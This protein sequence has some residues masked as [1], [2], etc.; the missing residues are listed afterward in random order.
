MGKIMGKYCKA[1]Q[2]KDLR[3]FN[4]WVENSDNARIEKQE[5]DGNEVDKRRPLENDS[6]VYLQENYVVTDDIYKEEKTVKVN[7]MTCKHC[8]ETIEKNIGLIRGIDF[9]KADLQSKNVKISGK[10]IDL[11]KIKSVIQKLG[12][13]YKGK[14]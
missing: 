13:D 14:V 4:G 3:S 5:I 12:Y 10:N 11:Q 1:Y 7:G 8:E 2:L 6:I 9:V